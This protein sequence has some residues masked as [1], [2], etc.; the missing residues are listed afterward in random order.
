VS[1]VVYLSDSL[2][3]GPTLVTDQFYGGNKLAEKGW[4]VFPELN[5]LVMFDGR[6]LHG[7]VPGR[8]FSPDVK[9]FRITFMVAFWKEMQFRSSQDGKPGSTLAFPELESPRY[10]W[11]RM[12]YPRFESSA[13]PSK[14][15]LKDVT[16]F[17]VSKVWIPLRK[18]SQHKAEL[19]SYD[20]CFQGF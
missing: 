10:T 9:G 15:T 11:Q 3:G 20:A 2:I 16:P 7:V 18:E 1:T 17:L 13:I 19:P 5:R 14:P 6:V 8:G 4:L 12:H